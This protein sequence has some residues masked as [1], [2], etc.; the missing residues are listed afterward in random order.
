[1]FDVLAVLPVFLLPKPGGFLP[2]CLY[3]VVVAMWLGIYRPC[4]VCLCF[5]AAS[6]YALCRGGIE[7]YCLV[8]HVGDLLQV[9]VAHLQSARNT[10]LPAVTAGGGVMFE[11]VFD[12]L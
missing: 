10:S 9:T 3:P 12:E 2:A 7:Q 1:M 11:A 4:L 6:Y 8:D 5:L